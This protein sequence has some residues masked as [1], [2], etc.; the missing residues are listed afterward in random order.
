MKNRECSDCL[1][2]R[3]PCAYHVLRSVPVL[4]QFEQGT[5]DRD[6]QHAVEAQQ[7]AAASEEF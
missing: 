3:K 5:D 2:L 1:E 4:E 7:E 6:V